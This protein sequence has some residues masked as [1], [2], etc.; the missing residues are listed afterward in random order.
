MHSGHLE[1]KGRKMSKSLK[2]FVRIKDVLTHYN[3]RQIRIMVLMHR[4]D[5]TFNYSEQ[6]M[7]EAV[8][9]ERQIYEFF[10]N[11]RVATRKSG[12]DRTQKWDP[13]DQRL[14]SLLNEK[15]ARV[16]GA[17][18]DS[19]DTPAAMR[20]MMEL[21]SAANSYLRSPA[22]KAALVGKVA[23]YVR[24]LL[25]SFGVFAD[26]S[27]TSVA[28]I[29]ITDPA[30]SKEKLV[31]PYIDAV[32]RFRDDVK[33]SAK[34]GPVPVFRICDQLRDAVLPDLGVRIEDLGVGKASVWKFE[35]KERLKADI[36]A[37]LAE[38]AKRQEIRQAEEVRGKCPPEEYFRRAKGQYSLFDEKG[39]PT[40][41][42]KGRKLGPEAV[43][44]LRKE[45]R[46]QQ[47]LH[48]KWLEEQKKA[49]KTQQ[50]Q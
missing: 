7:P 39:M 32:C 33:A 9:L 6:A 19:F 28:D 41:D 22:V 46:I 11:A 47:R 30:Q 43:R 14:Y 27:C 4:W 48:N 10:L 34:Q 40:H 2:N 31:S 35:D 3:A 5:A 20:A 25:A 37:R 21:I 1:I 24:F 23:E 36:K 38:K 15:R 16:H 29:S 17:L 12:L 50:Q 26:K 8:E 44:R 18:C 45:Y 49:E 42:A 13:A